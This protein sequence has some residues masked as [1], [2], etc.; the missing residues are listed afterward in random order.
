MG[1]SSDIP[2]DSLGDILDNAPGLSGSDEPPPVRASESRYYCRVRDWESGPYT[3]SQLQMMIDQGNLRRPDRVRTEVSKCWLPCQEIPGLVFRAVDRVHEKE[4]EAASSLLNEFFSE[5]GTAESSPELSA[6]EVLPEVTNP[7][8]EK[9]SSGVEETLPPVTSTDDNTP[10]SQD[11]RTNLPLTPTPVAPPSRWNAAPSAASKPAPSEKPKKT[12]RSATGPR[13][14]LPSQPLLLALSGLILVLLLVRFW[15]ASSSGMRGAIAIDGNPLTVGS[16]SL[17]NPEARQH[18]MSFSVMDGQFQSA[19]K[20]PDG[21]YDAEIVV[22][23]PLGMP[24]AQ[25]ENTAFQ[26]LNGARFKA[27]VAV[28]ADAPEIHLDLPSIQ[29]IPLNKGAGGDAVSTK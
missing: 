14:S 26:P 4:I 6:L 18:A 9:D 5:A 11:P 29:A 10:E 8:P 16:L 13:F 25:L 27:K 19:E 2:L 12:K 17:M 20:L 15:P 3:I 28:R 24:V 1:N 7:G 22:G 21:E 23:S